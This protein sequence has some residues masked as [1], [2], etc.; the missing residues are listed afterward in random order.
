M[1]EKRQAGAR[2]PQPPR[3]I[4]LE[5]LYVAELQDIWDL[6]TTKDGIESW[7]GP[8]GFTV[9]VRKLDLR[10]GG[11]LLYAMTASDP[12]QVEYMKNAGMPLTQEL[13]ITYTEIVPLRRLAYIHVA[14]FIPGVEPYDVATVVELQRAAEGVRMKLTLDAMHT[15]EWTDRALMGWHSQL[16]KLD[17]VSAAQKDRKKEQYT[18]QKITPF[19]WFDDKA[20]EA[21]NFYV[22]IFKNSKVLGTT[23][24]PDGSVF[25]VSFELNGQ[26]IRGMNAGPQFKFSEAISLFVDCETQEEVDELWEKLTAGG[27][28][29]RCGWLKD[30]F[31]L[32]WQIVPMALSRLMGDKDPEKAGRVMQA[33]LK[34]NKIEIAGLQQAYDQQ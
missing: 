30:K 6:W 21:M 16:G 22:S 32:S 28:E 26:E 8:G 3:R 23:P 31:G 4:T 13:R 12:P 5:R 2:A 34:M 24:G 25:G 29:S 11:E 20:E 27:E 33:M 10:P 19:L 14:D 18:M 9:T 1:T 17:A 15:D 7:W